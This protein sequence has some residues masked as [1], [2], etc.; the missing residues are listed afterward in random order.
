MGMVGGL[1][2]PCLAEQAVSESRTWAE[3]VNSEVYTSECDFL[4][5]ISCISHRHGIAKDHH[6][7]FVKGR[8]ITRSITGYSN[9]RHSRESGNPA[10]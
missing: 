1:P 5:A 2:A 9:I 8:E 7:G 4:I 3:P 10:A 6:Y